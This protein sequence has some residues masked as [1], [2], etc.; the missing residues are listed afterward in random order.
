MHSQKHVEKLSFFEFQKIILDFQL[1][2]H[3]KFLSKFTRLFK[4]VDFDGNG[5][6]NEQE[7]REL[8]S[9]MEVVETEEEVLFLLQAVDPFNNQKMTFSE[10]VHLLSSH[11][12]AAK[13]ETP[14]D[15]IPLLEKFVN[16]DSLDTL[17]LVKPHQQDEQLRLDSV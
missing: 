4:A 6:I 7:F 17:S 10:V 2:E 9:S 13:A 12:V 3:E 5:A 8:L 15:K 1:Q 14:Q 16:K 11:M